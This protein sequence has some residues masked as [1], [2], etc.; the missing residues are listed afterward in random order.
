MKPIIRII[1]PLT[2]AILSVNATSEPR[3]RPFERMDR[4]GDGMI[5]LEEFRSPRD[6]LAQRLER[7]DENG[8]GQVSQSEIERARASMEARAEARMKQRQEKRDQF[9]SDSDQ[10]RNGALS[11]EE[12]RQG[13]FARLDTNGDGLLSKREMAQLRQL[14]RRGPKG[15]RRHMRGPEGPERGHEPPQH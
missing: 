6:M 3:E 14:A 9:F 1:T 2:L 13:M 7:A 12:I 5:S 10:D 8:D 15:E 4:D 11:E